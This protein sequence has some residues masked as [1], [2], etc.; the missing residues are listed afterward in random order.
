VWT[1]QRQLVGQ[2]ARLHLRAL[3]LPL[4][5]QQDMQGLH[6]WCCILAAL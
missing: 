2:Q 5:Q 4:Q 3:L 6:L 1:L